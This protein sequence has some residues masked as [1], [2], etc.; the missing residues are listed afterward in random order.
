MLASDA[1]EVN[2]GASHITHPYHRMEF[3]VKT[4][5]GSVSV[6]VPSASSSVGDLKAAYAKKAKTSVHRYAKTNPTVAHPH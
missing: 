4:K 5:K 3:T 2:P 6:T 1:S